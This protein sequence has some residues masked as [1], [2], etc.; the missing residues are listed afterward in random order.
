M[1]LTPKG[2]WAVHAKADI[3]HQTFGLNLIP[4]HEPDS[5]GEAGM[6]APHGKWPV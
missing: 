5:L 6:P 1:G 4:H 2:Y 3:K